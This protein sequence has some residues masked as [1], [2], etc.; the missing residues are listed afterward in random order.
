MIELIGTG[1]RTWRLLVTTKPWLLHRLA[2]VCAMKRH[3]SSLEAV[4]VQKLQLFSHFKDNNN[5]QNYCKNWGP[6]TTWPGHFREFLSSAERYSVA[7]KYE[8]CYGTTS[9][10]CVLMN[11]TLC[12]SSR[13]HYPVY[14]L[15]VKIRINFF[16]HLWGP[17]PKKRP[18]ISG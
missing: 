18:M 17:A 1:P 13:L 10:Q 11:L 12:K 15:R 4:G 6:P 16:K 14:G 3:T 5:Y 8:L 7:N 2:W 9:A